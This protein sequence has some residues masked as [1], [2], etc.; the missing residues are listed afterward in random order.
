[1]YK[2]GQTTLFIIIAVIIVAVA[3]IAIFL[4]P[5][6]RD[7][8]T[9]EEKAGEL[10]ASQIEP[11]RDAIYDCVSETSENIF[12]TLG[13]QAGYYRWSHVYAF[14]WGE[15]QYVVVM[16]KFG[17]NKLVNRLP[18]LEMIEQEFQLALEEEGYEEIESC[19]NDFSSFK[20]QIGVEPEEKDFEAEITNDKIVISVDWPITVS[21]KYATGTTT[22]KINQKDVILSIPFKDLLEVA[23]D[24]VNSEIAGEKFEGLVK[25]HYQTALYEQHR[26]IKINGIHHP[27]SF[28]VGVV[29][30]ESEPTRDGE[31]PFKFQ[32]AI[33]R[34]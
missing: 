11:L 1:M 12:I 34:E 18:S 5:S 22:Q 30:L 8:F 27:S 13:K 23:Q 31:N 25:Q 17:G 15:D 29:I 16:D 2:R 32:F 28:N 33:S 9:S 21:K 4:W 14:L 20:R 6:I 7:R 26:N 19:L 10:L 3:L 24:I